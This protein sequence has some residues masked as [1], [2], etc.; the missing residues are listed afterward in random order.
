MESLWNFPELQIHWY[1]KALSQSSD[2]EHL[3]VRQVAEKKMTSA[4]LKE[5]QYLYLRDWGKD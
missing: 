3:T 5:S 1:L 2:L 4:E